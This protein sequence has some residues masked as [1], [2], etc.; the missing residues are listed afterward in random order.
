MTATIVNRRLRT[1]TRTACRRSSRKESTAFKTSTRR[2]MFPYAPS[3]N[4]RV[5]AGGWVKISDRIPKSPEIVCGSDVLDR[6]PSSQR[7]CDQLCAFLIV[8]SVQGAKVALIRAPVDTGC[9][10][11][12][13]RVRV[14]AS[15]PVSARAV[16]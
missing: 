3:D 10:R 11:V 16:G 1:S 2:S 13:D 4:G 8:G 5:L 6:L 14:A 15:R 12:H 7:L 9:P